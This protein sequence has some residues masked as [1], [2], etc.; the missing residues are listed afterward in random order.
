MGDGFLAVFG[1]PQA[2]ENDP[3]MAVRAGLAV[4]DTSREIAKEL[5]ARHSLPDFRVRVGINT[6]LV[7]A[8]GVTE[9]EGTVMGAP[10]NL[11]SRL[12]SAAPPDGVLISQHT[13]LHVRDHFEVEPVDPVAAKGFSEPVGAYLVNKARPRSFQMAVREVVGVST[14]MVGRE[15][16]LE[17]LKNAFKSAVEI[18]KGRF[19][20]ILG[21]AGL[22]KSRLLY[23]FERWLNGYMRPFHLFKGQAV[24]EALDLPHAL[25]REMFSLRFGILDDDP[26]EEIRNKVEA[27]F[28]NDLDDQNGIEERAHLIGDLLGFDFQNS[29]HIRAISSS[30][31]LLHT[32]SMTSLTDYFRSLAGDAPVVLFLDDIHWA[33]DSSLDAIQEVIQVSSALPVIIVALSRP[34]INERRPSW[35][36]TDAIEAIHL[37]PLTEPESRFLI[38]QALQEMAEIPA[39]LLELVT[40][41][42]EGNPFYIEELI[43]MLVEDGVVDRSESPWRIDLSRLDE[44]HIPS[45]LTGV[46]QSRLDSLPKEERIVL[47]Q[48]SV[49]GRVF[50]DQTVNYITQNVSPQSFA[51]TGPGWSSETY[52]SSLSTREMVFRQTPSVFSH[53]DEYSFKH[54]VLRDVT[55]ET[56]LIRDRQI[57]HEAVA[58]WLI[59]QSGENAPGLD[60]LIASHYE[61]SGRPDE[62][63]DYFYRAALTAS[64]SYAKTEA[65]DLFDRA[66]AHVGDEDLERRFRI[67]LGK[68][69][70]YNLH[71]DRTEQ[72]QVLD[73]LE[74]LSASIGKPE[75]QG[76]LYL[77]K[78]WY[79]FWTSDFT[80]L[81]EAARQAIAICETGGNGRLLGEA[82][83][84]LAWGT[85]Q[86]GD[87]EEAGRFAE[88]A[89]TYARETDDRR[90]EGNIMN[91]LGLISIAQGD[92]YAARRHLE[93]FL[94]IAQ[95]IG[96]L[97]RELTALSNL[98][99]ALTP[100]GDYQAAINSF[101]RS[102]DIANELGDEISAGTSLVNLAWVSAAKGGWQS[103]L[104]YGEQGL[105]IKRKVEHV[106]AVAE[107]LLW[108][109]HARVG[110]GKPEEALSL[111]Y[112]SRQIRQSLKQEHLEMGVN[113]ALA[114]AELALGSPAA[115][116]EH[117]EKILAYLDDGG[118]FSGT[119]EPVRI[120]YS[121][122]IT[123]KENDHPRAE[124]LLKSGHATLQAQ[125]SLIPEG[126]DREMFLKAVP[127]NRAMAALWEAEMKAS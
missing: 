116:L 2:K 21:E 46:I 73:E 81:K 98:G 93:K 28:R 88:S 109:G 16:E 77:R 94:S 27:G 42:A 115:A 15:F 19:L 36:G 114:R 117:V 71:G 50:W 74:R 86:L 87:R 10:V 102:L 127:W 13:Y 111:Y 80:L 105:A 7:V 90:A 6:G 106:E 67:L 72:R 126:S 56:V 58:D 23:E 59:D 34:A 39:D 43:K 85:L 32:K 33:D 37:K 1:L 55:Y 91:I 101:L 26:P 47:Q 118:D 20:L 68:E 29:P 120:Y 76:E 103:A 79:G 11:A 121:C 82:Y 108:L 49:V 66:L 38:Q 65:I 35:H 84:A 100:L 17:A 104:A 113:A 83:Y 9:A 110:L 14:D 122:Y 112:E 22:G 107:V 75:L 78:G 25:L 69:K 92:F 53:A 31:Q 5:I 97:E 54:A 4:I 64:A 48:A 95:E 8:G 40:K 62:S 96:D 119:W 24:L 57:Y 125:A 44:Y 63:V 124:E 99:A 12:E 123:L 52:L 60:G 30:P 89:L 61:K 45:T 70:V 41:N 51:M 3:E 18:P